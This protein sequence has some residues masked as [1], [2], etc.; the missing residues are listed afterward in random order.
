MCTYK[1]TVDENLIEQMKPT[2]N[3]E[4]FGQWLQQYVDGLVERMTM[5]R[6]M[7]SPIAYTEEEMMA[8]VS[9]RIR[10]MEAGEAKFIDGEEVFAQI[11]ERYGL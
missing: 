4:S 9:E 2:F 1:I 10:K 5:G 11:R 6:D 7:K 3:K 8:I